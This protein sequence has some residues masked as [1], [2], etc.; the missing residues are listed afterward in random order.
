MSYVRYIFCSAILFFIYAVVRIA[1]LVG[2]FAKS[3]TSEI[4]AFF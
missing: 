4:Q 1:A 2:K 3:A